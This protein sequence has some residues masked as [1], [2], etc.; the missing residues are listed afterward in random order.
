MKTSDN[1]KCWQYGENDLL[2][3]ASGNV[4]WH[5]WEISVVVFLNKTYISTTQPFHFQAFVSENENLHSHETN[6][7]EP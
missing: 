1:T 4:K 7:Q 5:T 2:Y 3:I 6:S